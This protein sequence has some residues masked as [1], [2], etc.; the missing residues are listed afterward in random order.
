MAQMNKMIYGLCLGEAVAENQKSKEIKT[1]RRNMARRRCGKNDPEEEMKRK[2]RQ[3]ADSSSDPVEKLR[4]SC[5][6]RGASG[7]KG[8]GRLYAVL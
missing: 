8:L 4:Y 1:Y 7:I 6:A 3:L 5:L 2:Y